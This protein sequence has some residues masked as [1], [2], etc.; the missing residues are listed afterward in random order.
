MALGTLSIS[1]AATTSRR[2]GA[3]GATAPEKSREHLEPGE[4]RTAPTGAPKGLTHPTPA[5]S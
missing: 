1:N 2:D 4:H 3:S 5:G